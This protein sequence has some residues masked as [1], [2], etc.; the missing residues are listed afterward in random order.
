MRIYP[1]RG[2]G[3]GLEGGRNI[4]PNITEN[5]QTPGL[6]QVSREGRAPFYKEHEFRPEYTQI[7]AELDA[8]LDDGE[9]S[10][11]VIRAKRQ[12]IIALLQDHGS[13]GNG[14]VMVI[15]DK[16]ERMLE[17]LIT[18]DSAYE[19]LYQKIYNDIRAIN[20][21]ILNHTRIYDI[22][23]SYYN[24]LK[25][26]VFDL[27]GRKSPYAKGLAGGGQEDKWTIKS[28]G[29]VLLRDKDMGDR[30]ITF[31]VIIDPGIT[32]D[33]FV[34]LFSFNPLLTP[35][36]KPVFLA[37]L[38]ISGDL[39][40]FKGYLK[41]ETVGRSGERGAVFDA[42]YALSHELPFSFKVV[43]DEDANEA[44]CLFKYEETE[45]KFTSI[46]KLNFSIHLLA[47]RRL[48]IEELNT[49]FDGQAAV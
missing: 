18:I 16:I 26:E 2:G 22:P 28:P 48:H 40:A 44:A 6:D 29:Y 19:R 15:N 45:D 13:Q 1:G 27:F 31:P 21:N 7:I 38:I 4:M 30:M 3:K 47:G 39:Y 8:L 37:E 14:V 23:L 20:N 34:K 49:V 17:E 32:Q 11:S 12:E 43:Y 10:P 41:S 46:I 33:A 5:M 42:E 36:G 24:G 25:N 35:E 9:G